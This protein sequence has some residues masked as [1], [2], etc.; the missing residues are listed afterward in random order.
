MQACRCGLEDEFDDSGPGR[1]DGDDAGYVGW[2]L[3]RSVR[4]ACSREDGEEEKKEK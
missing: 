4:Q 2:C 3:R 1:L